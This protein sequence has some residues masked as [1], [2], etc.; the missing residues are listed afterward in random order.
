M[1]LVFLLLCLWSSC[2]GRD[3]TFTYQLPA[4]KSECFYEFINEGAFMEIE[5]QVGKFMYTTAHVSIRDPIASSN[6]ANKACA[7]YRVHCLT[8]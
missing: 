1:W 2:E 3:F 4:G 5:Y 7:S 8:L 6:A